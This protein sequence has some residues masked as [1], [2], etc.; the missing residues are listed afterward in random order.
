MSH[1]P[2]ISGQIVTNEFLIIDNPSPGSL[3]IFVS[4]H[5]NVSKAPD[6]LWDMTLIFSIM[7]SNQETLSNRE[8]DYA[9][10]LAHN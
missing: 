10:A 6:S 9:W 1:C 7:T 3:G 8:Q 4:R 2:G 5:R